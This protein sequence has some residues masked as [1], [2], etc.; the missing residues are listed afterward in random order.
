MPNIIS[1]LNRIAASDNPDYNRGIHWK[2]V[3]KYFYDKDGDG[4]IRWKKRPSQSV[5]EHDIAGSI[6]LDGGGTSADYRGWGKGFVYVIRFRRVSF[7]R[8]HLVFALYRNRWVTPG[9]TLDHLDGDR[10]N[11]CISNLE[12]VTHEENLRRYNFKRWHPE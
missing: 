6:H 12:E 8:S 1:A 5:H 4:F 10:L 7:R 3:G 9:M 11:D 2:L